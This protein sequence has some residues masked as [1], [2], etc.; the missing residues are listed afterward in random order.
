M[1]TIIAFALSVASLMGQGA[2]APYPLQQPLSNSGQT[3]I[4]ACLY[5]YATGTTTPLATYSNQGLTIAN[6]NPIVLNAFGRAPAIFISPVSYKFVLGQRSVFNTCP[7]TPG[8]VIWSQDPVFDEGQVALASLNTFIALLAGSTGSAQIGYK[9]SGGATAETVQARLR[10]RAS[11]QDFGATTSDATGATNLAAFNACYAISDGCE[12]TG[13]RG[14]VYNLSG[15]FVMSRNSSAFTCAPGVVLQYVGTGLIDSVALV[16]S[17]STFLYDQRFEG[18]TVIGNSHTTYAVHAQKTNHSV[19][20]NL[21]IKD[22]I[23]SALFIDENVAN[24]FESISVSATTGSFAYVPVNGIEVKASNTTTIIEPVVE[25]GYLSGSGATTRGIYLHPGAT[26]A[27]ATTL[28]GGTSEGN[29]INIRLDTGSFDTVILNMDNE[30]SQVAD[31]L[32]NGNNTQI[33]GGLDDKLIHFGATAVGGSV[34]GNDTNNITI[35]AGAKQIRIQNTTYGNNFGV[36]TDN[37]TCTVISQVRNAS[38]GGFKANIS[39]CTNQLGQ[40]SADSTVMAG[41]VYNLVD[42]ALNFCV[43]AGANNALTC[44]L[45]NPV[46]GSPIAEGTGNLRVSVELHHTLQAGANTLTFNG[47]T[48]PI[49]KISDGG[50]LT[51]AYVATGAGVTLSLIEYGGTAWLDPTQ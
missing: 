9:Y 21:D 24:R 15:Q 13:A 33:I 12:A 7:A 44:T 11:V 26:N 17:T 6:T 25:M 49:V 41:P 36:I 4:G 23:T 43:D 16:G 30:V 2:F 35:D 50:N 1:K 14:T 22:A 29:D 20:S 8:T 38:G 37:G 27:E 47:T 46:T 34:T 28:M 51:R 48:H 19:L 18:C 31:I 42:G 45:T 5:T 39:G 40:T 3:L 32:D 10:Q